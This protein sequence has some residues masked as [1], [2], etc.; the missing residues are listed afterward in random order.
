MRQPYFPTKLRL[1]FILGLFNGNTPVQ[2]F[3]LLAMDGDFRLVSETLLGDFVTDGYFRL[4]T[5]TLLG[6][7]VAALLAVESS[8]S[9]G[10]GSS[11][12]NCSGGAFTTLGALRTNLNERIELCFCV[13]IVLV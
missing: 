2:H 9:N 6:D 5:E 4:V 13:F 1:P 12:T 7:L 3:E 11:D 8:E 10:K